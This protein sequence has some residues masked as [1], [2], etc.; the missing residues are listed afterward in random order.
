MLESFGAVGK[1]ALRLVDILA[2]QAEY[3][4]EGVTKRA[5]ANQM[6]TRLSIALQRGNALVYS[7]GLQRAR[8]EL[9]RRG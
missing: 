7:Q 5:F 2:K 1:D 6:L 4:K 8:A 3:R 9:A